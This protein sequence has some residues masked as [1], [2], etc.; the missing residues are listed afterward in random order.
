MLGDGQVITE[1]LGMMPL[2]NRLTGLRDEVE[3]ISEVPIFPDG[4]TRREIEV[5]RLVAAGMSNREIAEK[6]VITE[7]TSATHVSNILAKTASS[8]RLEAA[9]YASTHGLLDPPVLA[10]DS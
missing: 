10:T 4:L 5:L 1:K 3:S 8:N 7:N 2:G 6:L 9:N